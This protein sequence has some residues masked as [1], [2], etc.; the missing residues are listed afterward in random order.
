MLRTAAI[1]VRK[2]LTLPQYYGGGLF[3]VFATEPVFIWAQAIAFKTL[4]TLL[5]LLALAAGIF[6]LVLKQEEPFTT[7]TEFLRG[8]LPRD[9]S[10]G[11]VDL[12]LQLQEAST[13]LTVFAAVFFLATVI[14]MFSTLRYVVGAAMGESRHQMRSIVGGYL[15]DLRLAAQVG[16]LFLLSFAITAG[17]RV[18]S[19]R[20]D[21]MAAQAGL[22]AGAVSAFTGGLLQLVTLLI[23]YA[24]TVGMLAQLYYLVPRPRVPLQSAFWGAAAAAVLFEVAKNGFAYYATYVA[25]FDRYAG[26]EEGL[27]GLGGVFGVILAFVFWVYLS[28]LIL[29]AG[30][31]VT[32]LHEKRNRPRRSRLRKKW[33]RKEGE[34]R[35]HRE[36]VEAEAA[37]AVVATVEAADSTADG[38]GGDGAVGGP[39]VPETDISAP[40]SG[41][42]AT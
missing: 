9:Q 35:K 12:V 6:G 15:F 24:L 34:F 41:S 25:N 30:A 11:L 13:G 26:P 16:T 21:S 23:P 42:A 27:G 38:P 31:A 1:H 19:A 40:E 36:R 32:S 29:V 4:V 20:S 10:D 3:K 8:F 18:L 7:V 28:G 37:E 33:A 17:A 39:S 2:A 22:D 5:P 14:T